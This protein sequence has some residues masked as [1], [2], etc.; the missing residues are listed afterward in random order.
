MSNLA[1]PGAQRAAEFCTIGQAADYL[2]LTERSIRRYIAEGKLPAFR[3]GEKQIR[4][5]V[6]DVDALLVPVP[7]GAEA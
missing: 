4:I 6:V 7:T 1:R 2:S 5:R 3:L